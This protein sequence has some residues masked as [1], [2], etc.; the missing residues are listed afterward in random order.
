VALLSAYFDD[1]GTHLEAPV[2]VIGGWIAPVGQWIR[3]AREWKKALLEFGIKDFHMAEFIANNQKSEFADKAYWNDKRK[4]VVIKRLCSIIE[5]RTSQG[6]CLSV[7]KDDYDNVVPES[8]R[9]VVGQFHY[10]Y[11]VRAVLGHIEL[12]RK[13]KCIKEP[14]EYVFDNM[15]KGPERTEIG[16]IFAEGCLLENALERYGVYDGCHSFRK[17]QD[18]LPLQAADTIAWMCQKSW[19]HQEDRSLMP[20]YLVDAWNRFLK[21]GISAKWQK[22]EQL[23]EFVAKGPK[24]LVQL[25]PDW[26][27]PV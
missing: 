17:R 11:A 23:Q 21:R 5:N 22:L 13:T 19:A 20:P 18:I 4:S 16:R 24:P 7:R 2:A 3:F 25:P 14:I 6:F 10:T 9:S 26:K 27:P 12:W 1:S 8:L 15:T